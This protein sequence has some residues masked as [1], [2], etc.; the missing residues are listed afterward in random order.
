LNHALPSYK[1]LAKAIDEIQQGLL[2]AEVQGI[3][4]GLIC[5]DVK[6][7]GQKEF[8][9]VLGM[10]KTELEAHTELLQVL[11]AL[12][13]NCIDT[14]QQFDF[15]FQLL[16]PEDD[17]SLDQRA[18]ALS[19]WCRGFLSGLS[20]RGLAF[21]N[22]LS[23]DSKEALKHLKEI[24]KLDYTSVETREEDEKALF[25]VAEYVRMVVMMLFSEIHA[26][27]AGATSVSASESKR[28]H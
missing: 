2:P 11:R 8:H 24:G 4:C 13:K 25:E 27:H 19:M 17:T 9:V 7:V 10:S 18:L 28:L 14:L 23:S 1:D 6:N 12:Y 5:A 26:I 3:F 22:K 20:A 15:E 21:E 16:L